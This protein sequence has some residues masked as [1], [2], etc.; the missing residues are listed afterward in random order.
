MTR[1][2]L[3]V[4]AV[5]L[6]AASAPG[7]STFKPTQQELK[8]AYTR[9]N[10]F[11]KRAADA[12]F[13]VSLT[14]GWIDGGNAL[15]FREDSPGGVKEFIRVDAK[16]GKR[17][18]AFDHSQLAK[19]LTST[20]GTDV[21]SRRLPFDEISFRPDGLIGF[22]V[23]S[24]SFGYN[25]RDGSIVKGRSF[26]PQDAVQTETEAEPNPE[27]PAPS[28]GTWQRGNQAE[29]R[30]RVVDGQVQIHQND[31]W[32]TISQ[33]GS[34]ARATLAPGSNRVIA[35]RLLPGERSLVYLL[36]SAVA[37][38]SRAQL[39]QRMYDQPGDKLDEYETWLI[40]AD[41]KSE[42]QVDLAPIM[43]GGQPW[44][45]PPGLQWRDQYA[46]IEFPIRGYQEH[47]IVRVDSK[48]G[49]VQV[50]VHETSPT[51][52]DQSKTNARL[53]SDGKQLIWQSERDG[54]SHLYLVDTG[55]TAIRQITRGSFVVRSITAV[56][57]DSKQIW[58]TAN[59]LGKTP[60]DDPYEIHVCRV[61]FD[62]TGFTQ[63]TKGDGTHTVNFAPNRETFVDTFSRVNLPPIH[64][65]RRVSDGQ[66]ITELTRANIRQLLKNGV[67]LPEPFVA[68]GRDGK[69]DI[70]GVVIKPS[71]FDPNR[72]Y[73]VIENIYA[74]PHDSFV[75]HGFRP[76]F[77]MH[78]LAE[79]G[80]IVVQIDGMGTNNRGKAFHDVCW[81][82]VADA[83]FPD[84]ILW[85]QALAKKMPQADISRV[86]I[87]GTSAGG[88]SSTGGVL[89]HPE[90]YKVA[91]SACGCHDNRIDKQ[92]WNEQWMGY[93][94]G[95]HYAAQ[96]NIT[97]ASNL[98]GH[99]LLI[100][101]EQD[102]NVPPETTF[103]LADALI[104]SQKEFDFV[105]IPGA[106]HTDGGPYGERKR[107]D[108]F[109]R[110]LHGVEPPRSND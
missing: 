29:E 69:T 73:P 12:T 7:Q 45:G 32:T 72:K 84:R 108:F 94:V 48:T 11:Q 18:P 81:K 26:W 56:D 17:I 89:F 30:V 82:N 10:E 102:R 47:K 105:V 35:F 22:V 66:L 95:P 98:K 9:A 44:G 49:K 78:R 38:S 87:Y 37:G 41:T 27:F 3:A 97:N 90:F 1:S 63:L 65:L 51:F 16:S 67:R 96:S 31:S 83:G 14:F 15:W 59:C 85:M 24:E 71:N 99:L 77:N 110:W 54:W 5:A 34:Y 6:I 40:E 60:E 86:G 100:V 103:R 93:P 61:N 64:E 76:F 42:T 55:T 20:L 109:V 50:V 68:K 88:Q 106:D 62:G 75:P 101:G 23:R 74:G 2:F 79:L 57:E 39:E 36:K 33:K 91:V 104:K 28:L 80:F 21:D 53:L 13:N 8:E 92:W 107:R 52:I 43:G 46:F 70:W 19:A 25:P 4:F 58:F